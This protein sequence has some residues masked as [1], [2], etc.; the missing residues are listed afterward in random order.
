LDVVNAALTAKAARRKRGS[1]GV[2]TKI[3]SLLKDN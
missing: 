2:R 1:S 3:D